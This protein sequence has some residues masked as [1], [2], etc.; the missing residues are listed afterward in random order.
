M[1]VKIYPWNMHVYV[2][3]CILYNWY[4]FQ[5]QQRGPNPDLMHAQ[6]THNPLMQWWTFEQRCGSG[7]GTV[8]TVTF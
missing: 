4:R 1:V 3:V 7:T 6:K 5:Q 2:P 8:G